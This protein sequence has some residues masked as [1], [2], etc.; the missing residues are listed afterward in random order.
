MGIIIYALILGVVLSVPL[1]VFVFIKH[2]TADFKRKKILEAILC[3]IIS[4]ALIGLSV[5]FL[6]AIIGDGC[7][8]CRLHDSHRVSDV[9]QIEL[10]LE[11]YYAAYQQYP[12]ATASSTSFTLLRNGGFLDMSQDPI[13]PKTG[14][15]YCYAYGED[16]TNTIHPIQ[17]YHIGA[18]LENKDSDML[19]NDRDFNSGA[20]GIVAWNTIPNGDCQYIDDIGFRGDGSNK[21]GDD[22]EQPTYD[23]GVLPE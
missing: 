21:C 9:R 17:Y 22:N 18:V 7:G 10:A 4:L 5:L 14:N 11:L 12:I 3:I 8:R 16:K 20:N 2:S 1:A 23:R 15:L 19:C 13:D 6:S